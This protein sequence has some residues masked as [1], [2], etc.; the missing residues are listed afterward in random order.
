M[1]PIQ[2]TVPTVSVVLP[3]YNGE[4]FLREALDS[5]L[6]QTLRDW[7]LLIVDDASMD[8]SRRIAEDYAQRDARVKV[9][10]NTQGKGLVGALN[11]GLDAAT[12]TYVAR[13]DADDHSLPE[14]LAKQV[15][16]LEA[17]PEVTLCGTWVRLT[18]EHAGTEW[19]LATDWETIRCTMLFYGAL[20]HP[21][22]MWRRADFER[23]SWRY[24]AAYSTEDYELWTRIAEQARLVNLPEILYLYRTHPD[25]YTRHNQRAAGD[26]E[27]ILRRQLQRLN[28]TPTAEEL[29]LHESLSNW[30][31]QSTPDYAS[32]ANA[33]LDKLLTANRAAH[34][35]PELALERLTAQKRCDIRA[36]MSWRTAVSF[37]IDTLLCKAK[38]TAVRLLPR[39]QADWLASQAVRGWQRTTAVTSRIRL[40]GEALRTLAGLG[41]RLQKTLPPKFTI[42]MAVLTY[43]RPD[44]LELCLDSLFKTK[45]YD[46]DITIL[47]C[48]D[49][50]QDPR[51]RE[52]IEQPRD[53]RYKIVRVF[54][55]KGPNN[56]GAAINKAM[57]HLL[58]LGDFDIIGWSDSDALFHPEWLDQ[59][60]KI[61]LWAKQHHKLHVL[62]PFSSFNSSDYLYH[63]VLGTYR[64]PHGNYMV[65]RQMGMLNY[66]YFLE[67]FRKL[68]YF[69]DD[70]DDE[71]LMTRHF[72][73]LGVRNFCTETSYVEHLGQDSVLNQWRPLPVRRAVHGMCLAPEGWGY[74][75]EKLSPYAYYRY[76]KKPVTLGSGC[77]PS[78]WPVDVLIPII[79]KDLVT[80]PLAIAGLRQHLR[81]PLGQFI[82]VSPPD[83]AIQDFC[84]QNGCVWRDENSALPIRKSDIRFEVNRVDRAGWLFQQLLKLAADQFSDAEH[85]LLFDADTVLLQPQRFEH[86]G[87]SLQLISD[88]YHW[89]YYNTYYKLFGTPP[90]DRFSFIAHH[91][92]VNR[93]RLAEL[94]AEL[95]RR[96]QRPWYQAILDQLDPHEASSLSEYETYGHWMMHNHR[97]EVELEYWFNLALPRRRLGR[98]AHDARRYGRDFRSV[99]Y[100]HYHV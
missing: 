71:I 54:T 84:R 97:A 94:R 27:R 55:P 64:S 76:L 62:G 33:W 57:H 16:Y 63:R 20:A 4:A 75:M 83:A 95:E 69:A 45:L 36:A 88:E 24:D 8:G 51:V 15:A 78:A 47:L 44:Y 29:D 65:K 48:D 92:L 28:L 32:R 67:D 30:R 26:H 14:R 98:L 38:E 89:P 25:S 2:K 93:Q 41:C 17:H 61:C 35:L 87:R 10:A 73:K 58:A 70:P 99:S 60:L 81:H 91:M 18:G 5:I 13:M 31:L 9:I 80:L 100:Q 53:P 39:P 40:A 77:A 37:G 68:G 85:I 96:H 52:L 21:T 90:T 43:E 82:L 50:S 86:E 23:H 1:N 66:F 3:V 34:F 7:E 59:T 72:T 19:K 46:Y 6:A 74:D 56:A 79:R 42:G 11:T 12:G 49:G 22:V